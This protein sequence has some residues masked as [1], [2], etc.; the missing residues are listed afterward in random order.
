[1]KQ[2]QQAGKRANPALAWRAL[3]ALAS[4]TLAAAPIAARADVTIIGPTV[5]EASSYTG[6][7]SHGVTDFEN[8]VAGQ[9]LT[10]I[11]FT[12]TSAGELIVL[13]GERT[14]LSDTFSE[15]VLFRSPNFTPETYPDLEDA[16]PDQVNLTGQLYETGSEEVL[17][18][19]DNYVI[20]PL[21]G[22]SDTLEIDFVTANES[23]TAVGL[24]LYVTP[25]R[26][27]TVYG[28]EDEVIGS[29]SHEDVEGYVFIGFV[30]TTPEDAI[31]RIEIN[32]SENFV[33][34]VAFVPEPAAGVASAV[35][36]FAV[37]GLARRRRP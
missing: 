37:F 22:T 11:P 31:G 7:S 16:H 9:T 12:M 26:T 23:A 1:M 21:Q 19:P 14:A 10:L 27:I 29:Y 25:S 32:G 13:D 3:V 34:D 2:R 18:Y 36:L 5:I 15:E 6:D 24:G 20:N 28:T 4:T 8:A 33:F 30:A 17:R 35:A